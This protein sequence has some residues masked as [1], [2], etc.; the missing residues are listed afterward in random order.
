[1]GSGQV[2]QPRSAPVEGV[3]CSAAGISRYF[4]PTT[5]R[6]AGPA[7]TGGENPSVKHIFR[8]AAHID[9]NTGPVLK[10]HNSHAT[11]ELSI[12]GSPRRFLIRVDPGSLSFFYG[13]NAKKLTPNDERSTP[14]VF[15]FYPTI[16]AFSEWKRSAPNISVRN[17]RSQAVTE[18]RA[19]PSATADLYRELSRSSFPKMGLSNTAVAIDRDGKRTDM[20]CLA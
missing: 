18:T 17:E 7:A 1:M 16:W 11:I 6:S 3:R 12:N 20:H 10:T 8:D 5:P 13:R 14:G 4:Y 15:R 19:V 2:F 9:E